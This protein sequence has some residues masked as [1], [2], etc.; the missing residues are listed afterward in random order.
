[1]LLLPFGLFGSAALIDLLIGRHTAWLEHLVSRQVLWVVLGQFPRASAHQLTI[2][3]VVSRGQV[4]L[5]GVVWQAASV[6][7]EASITRVAAIELV[8][9][10]FRVLITRSGVSLL[11]FRPIWANQSFGVTVDSEIII[12]V[13]GPRNESNFSPRLPFLHKSHHGNW[14]TYFAEYDDTKQYNEI[15]ELVIDKVECEHTVNKRAW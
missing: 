15:V 2:I 8:F 14:G 9:L 11:L 1:M 3:W 6:W 10:R 7:I 4:R 12:V 5:V 13:L